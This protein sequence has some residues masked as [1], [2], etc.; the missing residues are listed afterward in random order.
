MPAEPLMPTG[1]TGVAASGAPPAGYLSGGHAV[2]PVQLTPSVGHLAAMADP[3]AAARAAAVGHSTAVG[4]PAAVAHSAPR[5]ALVV[6]AAPPDPAPAEIAEPADAVPA[7]DLTPDLGADT[8]GGPDT[9]G[10]APPAGTPPAGAP[11]AGAAAGAAAAAGNPDELVK[12]LFDPLLRRLKTELRLDRERR[13][14]LTD[15]RH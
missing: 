10:Q 12:K 2:L 6:Q 9:P 11:A 1:P 14:M 13:G 7:Q 3:A 8:P 4:Q 15:L 5:R